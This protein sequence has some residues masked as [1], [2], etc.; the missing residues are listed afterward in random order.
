MQNNQ[1]LI[2]FFRSVGIEPII[3][4]PNSEES[5]KQGLNQVTERIAEKDVPD[6][7]TNK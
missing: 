2:D 4:N 6:K 5:I 1:D 7:N 3:I